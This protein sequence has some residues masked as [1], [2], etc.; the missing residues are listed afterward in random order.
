[1]TS[2]GRYLFGVTRGLS[3]DALQDVAGLRG[4]PVEV[5]SRDGLQGVV[6]DVALDEFGEH[7]L[8]RNL[9]DL[10]WLEE[11]ARSHDDVVRAVASHATVAPMRLVTI[12]SG[13]ESVLTQL[14]DLRGKFLTAL[15]RV[16]GSSEW[17]VKV[18]SSAPT[19]A[20]PAPVTE[21]TPSGAAYLQRKRDQA[22]A[23]RT[24]GNR[25]AAVAEQVYG[26]LAENATAGRR[27]ALQDPRL[28]GRSDAMILNAAFLV[29][30]GTAEAFR[31]TGESTSERHPSVT[32]EIQGPW[33]PYSFSLLD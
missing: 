29:P 18:Y 21:A 24:A 25:D 31:A 20:S 15:D 1:V 11:V 32:I 7:A 22:N 14:D 9:E 12:Y 13:D 27:L 6:C 2:T 5:I 30:H 10:S 8:A 33:P 16:E 19:A 3:D 28:T 26:A 23:R 4:A 17:A